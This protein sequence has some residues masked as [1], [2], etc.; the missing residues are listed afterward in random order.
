MKKIY[1]SV[2]IICTVAGLIS[3]L[4]PVPDQDTPDRNST[5][6]VNPFRLSIILPSS[7]VQFYG[8]GLV[9][10]SQSKNENKMLQN[11]ISF[12]KTNAYYVIYD[13]TVP[14]KHIKFSSSGSFDVPCDAMTFNS[15][16]TV[17]YYTRK[18]SG[19][20]QE[21]IYRAEYRSSKGGKQDWI[22]D[23]APLGICNDNFTYSHPSL[24]ADGK[25]MVFSSN[26]KESSGGFDIFITRFETSDW[27]SPV[28]AG[29]LINTAGDEVSP[30][31]DQKNNL[32]FSSD[33]HPG[34]GGLDIYL[35]KYNGS[36]WDKPMNLTNM[37][38]TKD[39]ELAFTLDRSD[40]QLA[41]FTRRMKSGKGSMRL[42]QVTF[43][44]KIAANHLTNLSN[45]FTYIAMG[46]LQKSV[47]SAPVSTASAT[48]IPVKTEP[49]AAQT[50]TE[51]QP[52]QEAPKPPIT[53]AVTPTDA[54]VYRIQFATNSKPKGNYE[55]TVNGK[56]YTTFEYLYN[57]DYK[58]CAG[59]FSSSN[60][61]A[62]LQKIFK[63]NGYKDAFIVV[64]KNNVRVLEPVRS[65]QLQAAGKPQ[66][67]SD[68]SRKLAESKEVASKAPVTQS[69]T[70]KNVVI[71]RVQF[72]SGSES[73][74]NSEMLVRGQK[75]KIFEYFYNG[76]NR[77]CV[78]E[79]NTLNQA[80]A[81]QQALKLEGFKGA[82]VV[83][84]KN[85]VRSLDPELFK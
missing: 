61:A 35:C 62:A 4:V 46:D 57:G 9:F 24:S 18:P 13:D 75:Y 31:L 71:F 85:N 67:D 72:A 83:A 16:Y 49:V 51:I 60:E 77:Y 74:G 54:P 64:F 42:Y 50:K 48:D 32:Y 81:L 45:A 29:I 7:G 39:D 5:I 37:I 27:S 80:Y 47:S 11:H 55:V 28:N 19:K 25:M 22:S 40:G 69:A 1:G 33:G 41:F 73:R 3:G 36:G 52:E 56:K 30:F 14:G 2:L 12:G 17:M 15:D 66:A 44:D 38:N 23:Q 6:K 20:D 63:Q 34:S 82:F 79:F 10:L 78:G 58:L 68:V 70:D 53:E 43:H 65:G 8:D 76:A 26:R 84:F 59:E 21:M